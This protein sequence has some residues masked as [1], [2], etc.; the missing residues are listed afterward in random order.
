[1]PTPKAREGYSLLVTRSWVILAMSSISWILT[2]TVTLPGWDRLST[3]ERACILVAGALILAAVAS[4]R[5]HSTL[6]LTAVAMVLLAGT[7]LVPSGT[8][9]WT[10]P[11]TYLGYVGFI[12][13]LMLP[14][15][16]GFTTAIATPLI[17]WSIW[18]T[19]PSNVVPEAFTV[20]DGWLLATRMLGAQ[21]LLWSSWWWL[22]GVAQRVDAQVD[23][24]RQ[25]QVDAAV[26]QERSEMWRRTAARV[27][28]TM[29]NSIDALVSPGP[30][31]PAALRELARTGRNSMTRSPL[32]TAIT[33]AFARVSPVNAGIVLITSALG[34]SLI[35]GWLYT[36]FVPFSSPLIWT[37]AMAVAL[38]GA[39]SALTLVLRRRE[40][41]WRVG[42]ALVAAPAAFPWILTTTTPSCDAIGAVSAAAS[43][44]G[45]A[46]VCIGLWSRI[47]PMIVGLSAWIP[48]A[49]L[50]TQSTPAECAFAP[51]VI[52]LNVATFLPL[53][54]I[55]SLVGIQ[56]QRRSM[57]RLDAAE[58]QSQMAQARL[59]AIQMINSE[60][61]T[62]L[63]QA[64]HRFDNI[65]DRG[66]MDSDDALAL[67]CLNARL[68]A[69][70]QIDI[71]TTQ[72]FPSDAYNLIVTLANDGIPITTGVLTGT[73]DERPI[74]RELMTLLADAARASHV[75]EV[76]L[77]TISTG[78]T[79]F[80]SMTCPETACTVMGL[81]P[82]QSRVIDDVTLEVHEAEP[83]AS[84]CPKV[85]LTL[86]RPIVR[87]ST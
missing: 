55:I 15:R 71:G 26:A 21:I 32:P 47:T 58:L 17:V 28:G 6:W 5:R 37:L 73:D 7:A 74:P 82:G 42:L 80:L 2:L 10:Y 22:R 54:T 84:G 31:D 68:R 3:Y 83:D 79:D 38:M 18:Q 35:A 66:V 61:N 44:S 4:A 46:I 30:V 76:R 9:V 69:A 60:L 14:R 39:V 62:T 78:D 25:Q 12:C 57:A 77:Q 24:L 19:E 33:P 34:G 23:E 53:V 75:G 45:F 8:L 49:I 64:A 65:A 56:R 29:L 87:S 20:G 52:V 1:M 85:V 70:V 41:D 48:G 13:S 43:I 11:Q 72:G 67:R 27:H 51:T 59:R 16:V 81:I 36:A 63:E 86:E 40:V 50:V